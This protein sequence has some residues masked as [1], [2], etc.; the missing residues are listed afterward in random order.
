[1]QQCMLLQVG[2]CEDIRQYMDQTLEEVQFDQMETICTNKRVWPGTTTSAGRN[3]LVILFPAAKAGVGFGE[4]HINPSTK[5]G[6]IHT[7]HVIRLPSKFRK[8][9]LWCYL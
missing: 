2:D 8:Q 4:S 7:G 1:M 5:S 3:A 6:P 9:I